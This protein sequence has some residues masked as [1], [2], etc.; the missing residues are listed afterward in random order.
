[1]TDAHGAPRIAIQNGRATVSLG[2][3]TTR[4][5]CTYRCPFCYVSVGFTRGGRH[6]PSEVLDA[7]RSADLDGVDTVLVSGDTDS[8]APPRA[9]EGV[10]LVRRLVELGRNI[11]FTTRALLPNEAWH[12]LADVAETQQREGRWLTAITS[13]T[14]WSVPRLEPP[15]IPSPASRLDQIGRFR[16]HGLRTGVALR[17]L[18]PVIPLSDY[19]ELLERSALFADFALIGT[20]FCDTGGVLAEQTMDGEAVTEHEII[21]SGM[22]F[23]SNKAEWCEYRSIEAEK[24]CVN[25]AQSLDFPIFHRSRDAFDWL[26]RSSS[27]GELRTRPGPQAQG[28]P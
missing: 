5:H 17:P 10:D 3:L 12:A 23:D 19:R 27:P 16:A 14:Q 21:A 18:L 6:A 4:R 13:L 8:F 2:S 1:M 9:L 11:A 20:W 28:R 22:D 15:P 26:T 25:R 24:W 7:V